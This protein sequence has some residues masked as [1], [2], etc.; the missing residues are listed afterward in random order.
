MIRINGIYLPPNY[1]DE[2][3][4]SKVIKEIRCKGE[5]IKRIKLFK[6]SIDARKKNDVHFLATVDVELMGENKK[7]KNIKGKKVTVPKE[8]KYVQP[9]CKNSSH[10]V[11]VGAG[12]AGLF[13]AYELITKNKKLMCVYL[14]KLI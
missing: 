12:P 9:I 4:K 7:I 5:D 8:Y 2:M 14:L 3:L 1:T 13:S 11:V 6:L 10:T